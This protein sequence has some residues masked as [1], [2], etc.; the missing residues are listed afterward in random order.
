MSSRP[1]LSIGHV[2]R[3]EFGAASQWRLGGSALY[4]AATA[5]RLGRDVTLVTRVGERELPRL[6]ETCTGLGIALRRLPSIVTTTFAHTFV[7]GH[8]RL[9][10]LARAR[11]IGGE[12]LADTDRGAAALLGSVVGEHRDDLFAD[13][14]GRSVVVAQGELRAFD[15]RGEVRSAPWRRADNVLAT[16]R[17]VVLSEEDLG[18]DRDAPS[19]WSR[20]APV[21]V[22]RAERGASL[23]RAGQ[24]EERVPAF[25]PE[26]IVDQTGAGD[27]FGAALLVALDE[28]ADWSEAM[29]F[30][31][32]AA[33]FCLEGAATSTLADRATVEHRIARGARLP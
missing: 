33:S 15:A 6:A 19:R 9:R 1:F 26:A 8:R 11:A 4:G 27:V 28:G 21:V 5:A 16:V 2:A 32:A 13:V 18:E 24:E 29:T 14:A 23:F 22:T 12:D 20:T 25:R 31:N 3:D 30:A 7:D 17:A 10:L